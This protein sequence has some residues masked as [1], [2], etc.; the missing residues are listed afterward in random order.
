MLLTKVHVVL[1][2]IFIG[3]CDIFGW[4]LI[5]YMV[6][7]SSSICSTRL[8]TNKSRRCGNFTIALVNQ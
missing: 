8:N 1:L 2:S 3:Y 6:A 4:L 5:L 7:L